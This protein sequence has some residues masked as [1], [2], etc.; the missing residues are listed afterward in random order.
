MSTANWCVLA[1]CAIPLVVVNVAKTS[2]V[3]RPANDGRYDNSNPREWETKLSG[4]QQRAV[5][6]QTN[7]F[8]AL[9]LFIAAVLLAQ[10]VHADQ[11]RIDQFALAFVGLRA[12]Y[13][14]IYVLDLGPMGALRSLV[15]AAGTGTSIALFLLAT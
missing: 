7:G 2:R 10:Q 15:W 14:L 11:A 4:W 3:F 6:A 12:V 13:T 1:A 5:A 8:E 9:P